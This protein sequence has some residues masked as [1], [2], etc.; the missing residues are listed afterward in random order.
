LRDPKQNGA[1]RGVAYWGDIPPAEIA[2][3]VKAIGAISDSEIKEMVDAL[4][5]DKAEAK[6]LSDTLIARRDYLVTNWST[7][8]N[9]GTG[10]RGRV[11]FS[12]SSDGYEG[13]SKRP[14][15]SPGMRPADFEVRADSEGVTGVGKGGAMGTKPDK[16]FSGDSFDQVKPD[17][18]DELTIDEKWEW[19]LGEGNPEKGG[20]M[21]PAAYEGAMK[22]LGD[23]EDREEA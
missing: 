3:Q 1:Q 4:I 22:K 18:W 5:S 19:M 20:T 2:R 9:S 13:R 8:K 23:E 15:M 10:R 21:S 14:G 11:G 12:S 17:K 16:K 6:K 7:G